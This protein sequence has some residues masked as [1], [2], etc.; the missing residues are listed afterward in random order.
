MVL[1]AFAFLCGVALAFDTN[2]GR[3]HSCCYEMLSHVGYGN[4]VKIVLFWAVVN[5]QVFLCV[6][7]LHR[8]GICRHQVDLGIKFGEWDGGEV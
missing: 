6:F 4:K 8:A 2:M 7:Y 1:H 5:T 3:Y